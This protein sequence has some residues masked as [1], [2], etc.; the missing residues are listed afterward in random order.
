MPRRGGDVAQHRER[1]ECHRVQRRRCRITVDE[2]PEFVAEQGDS[3]LRCECRP[4][5]HTES[6]H[7]SPPDAVRAGI[8]IHPMHG[9]DH[10]RR[11]CA[12]RRGDRFNQAKQLRCI[13]P[14]QLTRVL[15]ELA[16]PRPQRDR[17]Q[18]QHATDHPWKEDLGEERHVDAEDGQPDHTEQ[19][20]HRDRRDKQIRQRQR[21]RRDRTAAQIGELPP[22]H[23]ERHPKREPVL[24]APAH[25]RLPALGF[26][27][28]QVPFAGR[29]PRLRAALGDEGGGASRASRRGRDDGGHGRKFCGTGPPCRYP[30]SC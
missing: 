13:G 7:P 23:P 1:G 6:Q 25:V 17:D 19:H 27:A 21:W 30:M 16:E 10:V 11:L 2:M 20:D 29:A 18:H 28:L 4:Q 14:V 3:L 12:D 15:V 26:V 8:R 24:P 9:E 5:R 22:V